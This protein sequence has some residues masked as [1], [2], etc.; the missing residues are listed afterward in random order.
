MRNLDSHA[1]FFDYRPAACL[2]IT[3]EDALGFLQGQFTQELRPGKASETAYGLWLNQ[4]GRVL[5]DSHVLRSDAGVWW[6]VSLHSPAEVIRERLEAY[7]IADDVNIEDFTSHWHGRS[8]WGG[9]GLTWLRDRLGAALPGEGGLIAREGAMVFR[10][11]RGVESCEW[12]STMPFEDTPD[13]E[14]VP[15]EEVERARIEAGLPAIPRDVGP[16]DLPNEAGLDET[17]ISYTKGCYLGQEVMARLKAMGRVRRRLLRVA[18]PSPALVATP[19]ALFQGEKK[20]GELRSLAAAD[21]G[22]VGLA[23]CTLL[24]LV[25]GQPLALEANG[26]GVFTLLDNPGG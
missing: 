9:A 6:L 23:M 24:A 5:A 15:W 11:R 25:P 19:A 7:V 14:A 1:G 2:R 20:V 8:V 12:L 10:L 22:S 16:E 21:E 26:P 13:L 3:G 17:A 18:S 4:K